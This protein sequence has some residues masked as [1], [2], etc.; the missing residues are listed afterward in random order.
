L[1]AI[2]MRMVTSIIVGRLVGANEKETAYTRVWESV[3]CSLSITCIMVVLVMILRKPIIGLFT[4][5]PDV[6]EIGA[7]VLLFSFLLETG[8]SINIVLVNSLRASGDAKYPLFIGMFSMVMMSVPLGYFLVF[9]L[10]LGLVG[11][12]LAIAA[13]EWLRA[14]IFFL[15]WRSR[16]WERHALVEPEAETN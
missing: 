13:D 14:C 4:D 8:R 5:H 1:F 7:Y 15:R 16:K 10:D 6:I 3:K 11:V 12:W 2:A 9:T